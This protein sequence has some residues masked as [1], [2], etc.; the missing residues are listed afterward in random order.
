MTTSAKQTI[1]SKVETAMTG[2]SSGKF[3]NF[4]SAK[5]ALQAMRSKPTLATAFV[6]AFSLRH[7]NFHVLTTLFWILRSGAVAMFDSVFWWL[8]VFLLGALQPI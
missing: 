3:G 7:L 5:Q 4:P 1:L 8:L 6:K 2:S